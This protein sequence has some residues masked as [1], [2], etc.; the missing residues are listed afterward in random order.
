MRLVAL[1]VNQETAPV[2]LRQ[3]LA[4]TA[5]ELLVALNELRR[6]R[7]VSEAAILSTCN[8]ADIYFWGKECAEDAIVEWLSDYR[9]VSRRELGGH[10]Y[11]HRSASAARHVMRV[12]SG[13]DSTV[14]GEPQ[15]FGQLK[16]TYRAALERGVTGPVLRALFQ[17]TFSTTKRVRTETGIGARPV[18]VAYAAVKMAMQGLDAS[19]SRSVALLIGAGETSEIAARHLRNFGIGRLMI[20]NRTMSKAR[21][22]AGKVGGLP[23]D[24]REVPDLLAEADVIVSST[25]SPEILI[26]AEDVRQAMCQRNGRLMRIIDLAVPLDVDPAVGTLHRVTLHSVDDLRGVVRENMESRRTCV[27]AAE[28]IIEEQV[29]RFMGWL[30]TREVVDTIRAVRSRAEGVRDE[31]LTKASRLLANG[32]SGDEVSAFVANTLTKKLLHTP[33]V[34]LRRAGAE[35]R[36]DIVDAARLLYGVPNRQ[37]D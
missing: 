37:G 16:S 31:V 20:A 4:F 28:K 8:R 1:G 9:D 19:P 11:C 6:C 5:D 33:T 24:L 25:A 32:S 3:R 26:N 14:L 22:L 30:G 29:D 18:S 17:R 2:A 13:L 23:V 10:L 21:R 12:A 7:G 34:G 36:S 27:E 15:I 35:G